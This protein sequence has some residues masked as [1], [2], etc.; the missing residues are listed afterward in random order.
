MT[1]VALLKTISVQYIRIK[2]KMLT[3]EIP[4]IAGIYPTPPLNTG[5]RGNKTRN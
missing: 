2:D 3:F 4:V 1:I 5:R